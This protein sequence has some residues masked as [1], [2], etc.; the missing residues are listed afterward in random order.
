MPSAP[1][2]RMHGVPVRQALTAIAKAGPVSSGIPLLAPA[3]MAP[4]LSRKSRARHEPR[5]GGERV[6]RLIGDEHALQGQEEVLD[7][8]LA[9]AS[10]EDGTAT[11]NT[12]LAGVGNGSGIV[13]HCG[14]GR[15]QVRP[16]SS[17][18]STRLRVI[19]E[20]GQEPRLGVDLL[21]DQ[22]ATSCAPRQPHRRLRCPLP[23]ARR[24]QVCPSPTPPPAKALT[25]R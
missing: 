17:E 11:S 20:A 16:G 5:P 9:C 15:Q 10:T 2:V 21:Q 22:E 25:A 13:G 1:R 14:G 6:V 8:S 18:I 12:V 3:P 7:A 24:H 19:P 4:C 23:A